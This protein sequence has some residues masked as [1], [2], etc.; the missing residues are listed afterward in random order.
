MKFLLCFLVVQYVVLYRWLPWYFNR[1]YER[2]HPPGSV[3]YPECTCWGCY[4]RHQLASYGFKSTREA[5]SWKRMLRTRG[6]DTWHD[7]PLRP[8]AGCSCKQCRRL[9][10][11]ERVEA[12]RLRDE[13]EAIEI[14]ATPAP[15]QEWM[16]GGWS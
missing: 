5:V 12:A 1:R 13:R 8:V 9:L 10:H 2:L 11:Q 16:T 7:V 14:E 3:R 4:D 6:Y 15:K